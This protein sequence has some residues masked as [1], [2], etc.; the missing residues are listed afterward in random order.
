VDQSGK[1]RVDFFNDCFAVDVFN[2]SN[3]HQEN[4]EKKIDHKLNEEGDEYLSIK[5]ATNDCSYIKS[6][7]GVDGVMIGREAYRNPWMFADADIIFHNSCCSSDGKGCLDRDI[8]AQK[9]RRSVIQS[10]LDYV[11]VAQRE[12]VFGSNTCNILKPLHGLHS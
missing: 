8:V 9:T 11:S 12:K 3:S 6:S 4:V 5:P 2:I 7:G 1:G 10:Y